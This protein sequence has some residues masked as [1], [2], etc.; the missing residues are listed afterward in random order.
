MV[1]S[2]IWIGLGTNWKP[3]V[4]DYM[5]LSA[6]FLFGIITIIY[7]LLPHRF[8]WVL[9]LV[10]SYLFYAAWAA[11]YVLLLATSTLVNYTLARMI[12]GAAAARQRNLYLALDILFNLFLLLV[13][14]YFG[15]F[16]TSL[17]DLMGAL[18]IAYAAPALNILLPVGI[19]FYTFQ[20]M[21]YV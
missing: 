8:R 7:Y 1:S 2:P 18:H 15:F 9:L 21:G 3:W 10:A 5:L 16:V 6:A 17:A 13:F 12:D 20:Q 19:S 4:R 14:K 11:P